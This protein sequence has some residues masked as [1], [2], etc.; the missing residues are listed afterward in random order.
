MHQIPLVMMPRFR[1]SLRLRPVNRIKHVVDSQFATAAGA[2]QSVNVIFASDTPDLAAD[3]EVETGS[4][5]NAIYLRVEV[6]NTGVTG[7][8]ANC[9][10]TVGKNPGGNLTLPALNAVGVSDNKRFIIHQ[11]MVMLNMTDNGNPRTL[12]NGVIVI[13]R[14]YRRMGP[15]DLLTV[16]IFSPGVEIT[17][18]IQCHYKEFR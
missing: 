3:A 2:T 16:S 4:T 5:V 15:N 8:L 13:P 6:V 7:I 10:L 9:Y 14:G 1:S 11:E 12:F 18:C 17:G